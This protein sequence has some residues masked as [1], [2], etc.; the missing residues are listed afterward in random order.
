M[1]EPEHVAEMRGIFPAPCPADR[2]LLE[3]INRMDARV[4]ADPVSTWEGWEC[5]DDPS[6][7]NIPEVL[8]F[9]RM[10]KCYDLEGFGRYRYNMLEAK[11][12]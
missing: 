5:Q 9:R 2:S 3:L 1:T 11:G 10:W 8:R 7:I 6:G 4:A 12:H